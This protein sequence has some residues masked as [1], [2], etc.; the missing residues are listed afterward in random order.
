MQRDSDLPM[1]ANC[2]GVHVMPAKSATSRL[3]STAVATC[4]SAVAVSSAHPTL[5]TTRH[6][7]YPTACACSVLPSQRALRLSPCRSRY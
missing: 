2:S 4:S 6:L 1:L 3:P 7:P 5:S